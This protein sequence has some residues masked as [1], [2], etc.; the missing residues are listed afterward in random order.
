MPPLGIAFAIGSITIAA[1]VFKRNIRMKCAKEPPEQTG[2][3][4]AYM[5]VCEDGL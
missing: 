2:V 3:Y 4:F 5:T 1:Q